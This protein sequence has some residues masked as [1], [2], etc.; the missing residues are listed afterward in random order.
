MEKVCKATCDTLKSDCAD[1]LAACTTYS[2]L[3]D[4]Y[5]KE[6]DDACLTEIVKYKFDE[7]ADGTTAPAG[8]DTTTAAGGS[9]TTGGGASTTT[10]KVPETCAEAETCTDCRKVAGCKFCAVS[11]MADVTT[12]GM[13]GTCVE[14][15]E[16]C[17]AGKSEIE[18]T[19]KC[20]Y[21][22]E[23]ACET[24]HA[25]GKC[26]TCTADPECVWC[27]S[28]GSI[29]VITGD[30]DL[31]GSCRTKEVGCKAGL[32]PLTLDECDSASS[33]FVAVGAVAM[34][35]IANL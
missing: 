16:P 27:S 12:A 32:D 10:A 1:Y 23:K 9:S 20:L 8:G 29:S 7:P 18:D 26:A 11:N 22:L 19:E 31:L 25:E 21:D 34:A 14:D 28:A 15:A 4:L 30:T 3:F 33:V 2:T 24:K 5:C 17:S 13:A 35:A 6:D